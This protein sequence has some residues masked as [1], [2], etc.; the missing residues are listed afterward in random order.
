MQREKLYNLHR[1]AN[2]TVALYVLKNRQSFEQSNFDA[3]KTI[4][5]DKRRVRFFLISS[6]LYLIF[7]IKQKTKHATRCSVKSSTIYIGQHILQLH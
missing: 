5:F 4:F 1:T 2:F 3:A 6:L 7:S